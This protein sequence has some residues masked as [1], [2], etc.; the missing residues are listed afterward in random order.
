ML[1]STICPGERECGMERIRRIETWARL[2]QLTT[3]GL[4]LFGVT[5]LMMARYRRINDADVVARLSAH[6]PTRH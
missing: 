3:I 4:M 1:R 5:S 6:L 2:A